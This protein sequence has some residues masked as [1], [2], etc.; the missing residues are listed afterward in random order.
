[1]CLK[2]AATLGDCR[3]LQQA[4]KQILTIGQLLLLL[5][6]LQFSFVIWQF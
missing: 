4:S 6:L 5:L 2:L 3:L 1:M